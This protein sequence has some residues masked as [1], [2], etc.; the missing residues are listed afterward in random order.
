MST[1]RDGNPDPLPPARAP[2]ELH[3]VLARQLRRA[4]LG[5]DTQGWT[6][7]LAGLLEVVS[8]SYADHDR[9]RY[10]M[11][12]SQTLASDE[13]M[14]LNRELD[15]HRSRLRGLLRLSS[16]WLWEMNQ[17]G[18]FT[19]VSDDLQERTKID[20]ATIL[21]QAIDSTGPLRTDPEQLS[22]LRHHLTTRSAFRDL[23]F[24]VDD[25]RGNV[26]YMKISGEPVEAEGDS[27]TGGFRGVAD[28]VTSAVKAERR[29]QD[30]ARHAVESQL[31]FTSRLLSANPTAM[32]V[33]DDHGRFTMVN[34]AWLS[35]TGLTEA[36]VIGRTSLELFVPGS[37]WHSDS[38]HEMFQAT[39]RSQREIH[40]ERPDGTGADVL[41]T[42]VA[43]SQTNGR[44][45]G[46]I[47]S[48]VDITEF[49]EAQRVI[50][51]A[52]H[53][54]EDANRAKE[55]FIANI[56][57]ELRT[58]LQAIIGF[59]ELGGS[60]TR[61]HPRW[62]DMFMSIHNA[63]MRMLTLVNALLDLSKASDI[64]SSMEIGPRD[65]QPLV[66]EVINELWPLARNR[67]I[68]IRSELEPDRLVADV[69]EFRI[70][71]VLRNVLANAI[72]FSPT[73]GQIDIEGSVQADGSIQISVRD[74]GPGIPIAELDTIFDPFVQS[75]RTRDG[76]GGTG[77]GLTI[78]RKIM[79]AH[80]GR[81]SAA[82]ATG[83]GTRITLVLPSS[84]GRQA[85]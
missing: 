4:G 40:L 65:L 5:D 71:Q 19:H 33:R 36:E 48:I 47:G 50:Q 41:I 29:T 55:E 58:P 80:A 38:D 64:H 24:T 16:D 60:R 42:K 2:R 53:T 83:G 27:V 85:R 75:S 81:I 54:A 15:Q 26:V 66:T 73:P 74:H 10:L 6:V 46:C 20:P 76:S 57:H 18:R 34:Q 28:D 25:G 23:S 82:N 61:D 7:G 44:P 8:Q 49:R 11:G 51:A 79:D 9:D 37:P 21:G 72:R 31:A 14:A 62:N 84:G 59:S 68:T 17:Y 30:A 3:P 13:L 70:Q 1:S 22:R 43:F 39:G 69:D 45:G 63:G 35:L 12:R 52:R 77:L 78:S 67:E 32:F 56:S